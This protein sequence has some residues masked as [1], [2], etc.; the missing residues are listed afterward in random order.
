VHWLNDGHQKYVWFSGDGHE[1]L[2]DLDDD[3]QELRDLAPHQ[4][5]QK[6]YW[7]RHL[8]QE[9]SGREEGF[10]EGDRLVTGRPVRPCLGHLRH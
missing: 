10:I 7:R 9:L 6:A 2:F 8:M 4:P 5:E 1:Q 3:P